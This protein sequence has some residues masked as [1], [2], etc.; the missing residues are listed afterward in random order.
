M[1]PQNG[2]IL[3][4]AAIIGLGAAFISSQLSVKSDSPLQLQAGAVEKD[5]PMEL[6]DVAVAKKDLP[7]GAVIQ[8][9]DLTLMALPKKALPSNVVYEI[10]DLTN[11]LLY[12][13]IKKDSYFSSR[14]VR[15][16]VNVK[17]PEGTHKYALHVVF[18][19]PSD[20][21]QPGDKVDIIYTEP[22]LG[23]KFKPSYNLRDLVVLAVNTLQSKSGQPAPNAFSVSLAVTEEQ[24]L[25]LRSYEN[26][27]EVK[28]VVRDPAE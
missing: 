13:N 3:A 12:R 17:I 5:E 27:G 10:K 7:V 2:M 8:E 11:K 19:E 24:S 23:G 25:L 22:S 28:T 14:E 6:V 15:A 4:F 9:D 20:F 1:K 21:V 16:V 26:R 18:N